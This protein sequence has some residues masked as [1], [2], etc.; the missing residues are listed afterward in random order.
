MP[1]KAIDQQ[2]ARNWIDGAWSDSGEILDS[3]SPSTGGVVGRF[4]SAGADEAQAAIAAARRAFETTGW[5]GDTK[6]RA[7]AI[8]QLAANI[9]KRIPELALMLSRE[10]GKLLPQTTWEMIGTVDVLRYSAASAL[11]LNAGRAMQ[12]APGIYFESS[13]VPMGVVG[14]IT[15]WNSPIILTARVIGPALAA[16]CAIVLKLPGQTGLT[17]AIFSEAVAATDL[18]P[19]GILNILTEAGNVVAPLMVESSNVNMINFT[20]STAV[21]RLVSAAGAKTLKRMNFE[22]G[23]KTPLV[24]LDDADLAVTIPALVQALITMNGQFCLTGSRVLVQRGIADAVRVALVEAYTS[25]RIGGSE[26]PDAQIGPV[27]DAAS[28]TR[29]NALVED[30]ASYAKILVRGGPVTEGPLS[31]SGAFY[32]PSLV[33]V[34]SLDVPIVQNEVFGPV[35]TFEI[36]DDEVDGVRRANATEY[37]LAAAVFT[38]TDA[39]ARRVGRALDAALVW[40]NCWGPFSENFEQGGHKQSGVGL[41]SGPRA[42]EQFQE[43][44]AYATSFPADVATTPVG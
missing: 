31:K 27:I 35:Q 37:G 18:L 3:I 21:G 20:G 4:V 43:M 8:E 30:A 23:G 16:G 39:R 26:D 11:L 19:P 40:T 2:P 44:K 28:A 7:R 38:T 6:L 32:R 25:V 29:I 24:V 36:F 17:N 5:S 33:E 13:P 41:L 14:V 42:I 22:L 34:E 12:T 15:P 1:S 9:E 10:G